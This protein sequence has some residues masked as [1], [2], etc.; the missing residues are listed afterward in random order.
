ML[1]ELLLLLPSAFRYNNFINFLLSGLDFYND[2]TVAYG[3]VVVDVEDNDI[4]YC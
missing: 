3:D 1:A 2:E 4:F